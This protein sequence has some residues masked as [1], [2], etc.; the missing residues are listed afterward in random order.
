MKESSLRVNQLSAGA[1]SWYKA[2]LEVLDR[3]DV[4]AYG[5]FLADDVV[6]QTNN[7]D[8]VEGKEAVLEGLAAYWQ[9]FGDLEHEPLNIYGKDDAFM[10][11]A[12]NHY[13]RKDGQP[14]TLRAVALTDRNDKGLVESIRLYSDT[15]PLFEPGGDS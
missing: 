15:S 6:M 7:A 5:E 12:L 4:E 8:P 10:L 3:K 11:E 1:F 13:T 14:V 2:Y 9:T